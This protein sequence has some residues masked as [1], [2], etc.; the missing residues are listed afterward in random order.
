MTFK[1]KL[2]IWAVLNDVKYLSL[3]NFIITP[4]TNHMIEN[5]LIK[6][7]KFLNLNASD[8]KFFSNFLFFLLWL[9]FFLK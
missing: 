7:F 5:D 1:D 6:S 9:L 8:F 2:M 4:K 3:T